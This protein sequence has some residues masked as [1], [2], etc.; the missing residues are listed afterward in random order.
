MAKRKRPYA[1][2]FIDVAPSLMG[3]G[4]YMDFLQ[5]LPGE[6]LTITCNDEDGSV[7]LPCWIGYY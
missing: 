7:C 3:E 5:Y 1:E 4:V 6:G 2:I